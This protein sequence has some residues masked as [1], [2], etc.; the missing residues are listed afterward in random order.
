MYVQLKLA[1]VPR[2]LELHPLCTLPH[3]LS[4]RL[5]RVPVFSPTKVL[6]KEV[7]FTMRVFTSHRTIKGSD[8]GPDRDITAIEL[9]PH[10]ARGFEMLRAMIDDSKN[11]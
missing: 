2:P 11:C 4:S 9:S 1:F 6:K 7:C 8:G 3:G 5:V 10:K